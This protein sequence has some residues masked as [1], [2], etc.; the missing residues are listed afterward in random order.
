MGDHEPNQA[1][2]GAHVCNCGYIVARQA[3][4]VM[5]KTLSGQGVC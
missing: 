1:A 3:H 5:Y 2:L 4:G